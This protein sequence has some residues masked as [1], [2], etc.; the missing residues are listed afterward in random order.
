MCNTTF[1]PAHL[2]SS[3]SCPSSASQQPSAGGCCTSAAGHAM[4]LPAKPYTQAAVPTAAA[5]NQPPQH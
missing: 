1:N 5:S 2:G 4:P 3:H